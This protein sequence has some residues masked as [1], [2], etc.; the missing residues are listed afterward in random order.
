MFDLSLLYRVASLSVTA[1]RRLRVEVLE[2]EVLVKAIKQQIMPLVQ[3][4]PIKLT[5]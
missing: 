5:R 2:K 4:V 1:F 3:R